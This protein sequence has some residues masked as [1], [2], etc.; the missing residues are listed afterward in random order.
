M[1]LCCGCLV[2]MT[3]PQHS[4]SSSSSRPHTQNNNKPRA[5][6][7]EN[8]IPADTECKLGEARLSALSSCMDASHR[9]SKRTGKIQQSILLLTDCRQMKG[10]SFLYSLPSVFPLHSVWSLFGL[11]RISRA[12]KPK[13]E[14]EDGSFRSCTCLPACCT[15]L[16]YI[17]SIELTSLAFVAYHD[18]CCASRSYILIQYNSKYY[19]TPE[20]E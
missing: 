5:F 4:S 6:P 18:P 3:Y 12:P 1:W 20:E 19:T 2:F 9:H 13:E 15:T 11:H 8:R 10:C 14:G 16:P 7:F 17:F